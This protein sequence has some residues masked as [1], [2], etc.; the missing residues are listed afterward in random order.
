MSS[1]VNI[2]SFILTTYLYYTFLKPTLSYDQLKDEKEIKNYYLNNYTF[3]IIYFF[4]VI[5]IQMMVNI[6]VIN[7]KCGGSASDNIG[8][9]GMI[10][11]V[12]WTLIFGILLVILTVYPGFKTAFSDVIG[13]YC[14]SS[15][16]NK[17]ITELLIDRDV[18]NKLS[19]S[20]SQST[21]NEIDRAADAIIK[22]CGNTSVLIN[23]MT[24]QNFQ[25]FWEILNPL[26][27]EKYRPNSKNYNDAETIEKRNSL[28]NLVVT[29][30]NIGEAM[31]YL[32]TG[33]L[34]TSVV[35]LKISSRGCKNNPKTMEE[36]YQ[37]FRDAQEKKNSETTTTTTTI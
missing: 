5:L 20:M 4:A 10:T 35:Q 23:Q 24:P 12:P 27:K 9:A 34:V 19:E 8:Y 6:N 31:W 22:I 21:K 1:Y 29:R 32:Y 2:V 30:D 17:I 18:E 36:N 13:Y 16:A 14:V 28:F 37:K 15:S 33:L 26:K 3:L 25:N 11:I 7:E